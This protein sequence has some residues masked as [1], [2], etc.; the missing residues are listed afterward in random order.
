MMKI[1]FFACIAALLGLTA[2][3][4]VGPELY[5]LRCEGLAEPL[6]IDSPN[7]HFSWKIR[8]S[9]PDAQRQYEIAVASTPQLLQK[10]KPDL[11]HTRQKSADQVMVPYA[12]RALPSRSEAFWRVRIWQG[13][14]ASAWSEPQR[15]G[16]GVI[17]SDTLQAQF[18]GAVPGEGRSPLL[19]K[20]FTLDGDCRQATLR[21]NVLGYCEAYI[22]GRKVADD[23]L[24]PAVSQ[25]DKRSLIVTYDVGSLLQK[26]RNEIVLW[27][28]CGWYKPATFGATYAG[29]LAKAELT[30][31]T[32]DG[33]RRL[34]GTDQTWQ[35]AWSGYADIGDW[36]P[37][38]FAGELI[39]GRAMPRSLQSDELDALKW[40]AVDVVSVPGM[41]ASPQMC[42]PCRVQESL[43][44]VS[45]EPLGNGQ[46][47]V[48]FGR[49]VNA[50]FDITL[51]E[52]P[53]G[54]ISTASFSDYRHHDG[55]LEVAS[56]NRY[57][58]SGRADG[59]HFQ[60]RFN[61][62][63]FRYVLLDSLPVAPDKENI[64]ARRMRTDYPSTASFTCSDDELN[65]IHDMV[66]YTLDN[67]AFNGYMVDCAN[68]ERL[69]YGGDGNASTQT[70]Q[71]LFATAPLYVNWLQAW[72]DAL[73]PDGGLPH[74]APNPYHAGGGP[75]WCSFIVQAPWRTYMN[76]GDPRLLERC[77][78]AMK[79]WLEYVDAYT[80][81][82][83]LSRWPDTDYRQWYLGDWAAP[84]G[85]DVQ[86][87]Q[88]VDLVNNCAM[89]QVY[90]QLEPI[91]R[92]M[93][94]DADAA[95]YRRRYEALAQRINEAFLHPADSSY[96][97][98]SQIDLAYPLLVGIVP[99]ASRP[100]VA[101]RLLRETHL[102]TGL[103]GVPV[104][105]EWATQAEAADWMYTLLKQHDFPGYLYMLDQ[106]ATATWEHWNGMRSR[107]HNCFNGIGS[108]FYQAL[109][110]IVADAPGYRHVVIRPQLPKGLQWVRVSQET[111]YG[112]I[113]VHRDGTTLNIE[114]PIGVTATIEGREYG[115]GKHQLTMGD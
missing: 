41:K 61:H 88:S 70:L 73:R 1:K 108:W 53:A 14:K 50:M 59:D 114:L 11:W 89:C 24:S 39:D 64:R 9:M 99:E 38:G 5:D 107:M 106:G 28:S 66:A 51:P 105:T 35:G 3:S 19:R 58:S 113:V 96:A 78:P 26:G 104:I 31:T 55:R 101:A 85:V 8:S 44:P 13:K 32:T 49:I 68:I 48:D 12:G 94:K 92:I 82:G 27:T 23:V 87:Q 75:Y 33:G 91:A 34:I 16:V 67:L 25:L 36:R 65:K 46:W 71:T 110:G 22:N 79:K 100:L 7:P 37:H 40:T 30:I 103:V 18:I 6:A 62:H 93:K 74:T 115:A 45:I 72:T 10:G 97:S 95:D 21:V 98:G 20:Q 54:H 42:E 112:T 81:D 57:V 56:R 52:L 60:N 109:G 76:Y 4:T 84:P 43:S 63:V 77:Y 2:C 111:P 69:G 83:L 15:F 17:G 29:P 90:K 86:N 47:L 102:L 80:K